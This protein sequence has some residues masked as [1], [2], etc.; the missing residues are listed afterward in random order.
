MADES[1]LASDRDAFDL[2]FAHLRIPVIAAP[3]TGVSGYE[4]V[5][6]VSAAGIGASFPVHNC[7]SSAELD[8]W[9]TDLT[10]RTDDGP[11]RPGPI[12]PNL[13]VHRFNARR[14][15]DL[16]VLVRHQVPA[17]I[18]SVG[19]P[20]DVIGPLHEAILVLGDVASMRHVERAIEVG[21]DALVLLSAGAGG[22]TGWANPL[23]FVS[24]VRA[25]WDG[26]LILAGGVADGRSLLAAQVAGYDL[27]YMGTPFIATVESAASLDYRATVASASMD[28]IELTSAFTGLPTSMIRA[29]EPTT[30]R[31]GAGEYDAAIIIDHN[32]GASAPTRFSAGHSVVAVTEVVDVASLVDRTTAGYQAAQQATRGLLSAAEIRR[33]GDPD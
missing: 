6:A 24:G 23:A 1:V 5:A 32:S 33:T 18:T 11:A 2:L 10:E 8:A 20:A 17:V 22:Q 26:P 25:M 28:D 12:M 9:L 16:E 21:V 13:I 3:M 30:A 31:S 27:A 29:D 14:E 4:L 7:P 15:T 19:S